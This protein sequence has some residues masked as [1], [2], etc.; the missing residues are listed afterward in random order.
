MSNFKSIISR[1]LEMGGVQGVD[2]K[3]ELIFLYFHILIFGLVEGG[4][5]GSSAKEPTLLIFYLS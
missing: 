4:G 3:Y 2:K 1:N 5:G